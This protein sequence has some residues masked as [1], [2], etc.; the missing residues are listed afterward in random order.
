VKNDASTEYVLTEKTVSPMVDFPQCGE[1][2]DGYVMLKGCVLGPK[3]RV[4]TMCKV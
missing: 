3:K 2:T 1:V 4:V